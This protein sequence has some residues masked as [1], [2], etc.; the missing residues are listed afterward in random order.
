MGQ[1]GAWTSDV[2]FTDVAVGSEALVGG[3]EDIG[4]RA[5]LTSL[6]REEVTVPEISGAGIPA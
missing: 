5:A 6:A 2:Y 3:S 1:E 4:Y